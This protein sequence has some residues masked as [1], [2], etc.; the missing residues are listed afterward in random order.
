M[1][2][3]H[4]H[5]VLA[6]LFCAVALLFSTVSSN[7]QNK[8]A[9]PK[10]TLDLLQANHL[11]SI[12]E[13][14]TI[15]SVKNR[16]L[17]G[18]TDAT[19]H[20]QQEIS[21]LDGKTVMASEGNK[22]LLDMYFGQVNY[23]FERSA[24]DGDTV[25]VGFLRPGVRSTLGN[26]LYT[27][28][29]LLKTGL[30]GGALSSAWPFLNG[31]EKSLKLEFSGKKKLDNIEVYEVKVFPK[32]DLSIS[33]YFS[34]DTFHH[35]RTVY[36]RTLQSQIGLTVDSAK[37]ALDTRYVLTEY[38]SDFRKESGLVLPHTYNLEF[39]ITSDKGTLTS[40]WN[41]T[42]TQFSFNQ[43]IDPANFRLGATSK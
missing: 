4:P 30:V 34:A 10:M 43:N 31:A 29:V 22:H 5:S 15:A 28:N 20:Y 41:N 6:A 13:L 33:L 32:V 2:T 16:V 25:T 12:G 42:L 38:F 3:L 24:Y 21:R 26:F 17:A 35:I 37:G 18:T 7:A 19:I 27:Y 39:S 1:K 8:T 9:E 40:K 36:R 14:E 11:K 23:P